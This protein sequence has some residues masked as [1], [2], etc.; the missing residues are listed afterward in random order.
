M[1]RLKIGKAFWLGREESPLVLMRLPRP[2]HPLRPQGKSPRWAFSSALTSGSRKDS[3]WPD[4]PIARACLAV[5]SPVWEAPRE[6]RNA[7]AL[8]DAILGFAIAL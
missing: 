2:P 5:M 4:F 3:L 1:M 7:T 8:Q 6:V